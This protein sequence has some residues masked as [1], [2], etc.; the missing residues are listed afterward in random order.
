MS[1]R[2]AAQSAFPSRWFDFLRHSA[3]FSVIPDFSSFRRF[4]RHSGESRNL[5]AAMD[6]GFRRS[7]GSTPPPHRQRFQAGGLFF[8]IPVFSVIP[9]FRHSAGFSVIPAKAGIYTLRWTPVFARATDPHLNHPK[10]NTTPAPTRPLRPGSNP[11]ICQGEP[12][13]ALSAPP[14]PLSSPDQSKIPQNPR[15]NDDTGP[16]PPPN[17]LRHTQ[18]MSGGEKIRFRQSQKEGNGH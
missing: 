4:F 13:S 6:S 10:R 11:A 2:A 7:D 1:N 3:G 9:V 16:L 18:S 15:Q 12:L 17:P 14:C 5:H 8:V